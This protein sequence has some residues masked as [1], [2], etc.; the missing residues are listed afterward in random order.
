MATQYLLKLVQA[1]LK[2]KPVDA[3]TDIFGFKAVT[4]GGV[5]FDE[6]NIVTVSGVNS[7][8]A[9]LAPI[10]SD[11]AAVSGSVTSSSSSLTTLI[12]SVSGASSIR[13]DLQD[14]V[15]RSV[16]GNIQNQINAITSDHAREERFEAVSGQTLFT[17]STIVFDPSASIRGIVVYKNVG[18][19]FMS[20][21]GSLSDGDYVKV[22]T[23]QINW[24]YPLQDGDRVVVREERTGGGGGGGGAT[25]LENIIVDPSPDSNGGHALGTSSR[26]WSGVYLKDT[27]TS[28]VWLLQVVS[29]SF[30]TTQVV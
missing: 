17:L 4:L 5:Q 13:D 24:L 7:L 25:D 12:N 8:T 10:N 18:R 29:G 15:V 27:M 20:S 28:N 11:I 14:G 23:N 21:T 2:Y 1:G 26:S 9:A 16:S 30:Q 22:G 6:T 19:V 3:S